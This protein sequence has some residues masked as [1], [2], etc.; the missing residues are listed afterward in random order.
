MQCIEIVAEQLGRLRKPI[1]ECDGIETDVQVEITRHQ[2]CDD[3]AKLARPFRRARPQRLDAALFPNAVH[4]LQEGL[5][6]TR[7][8]AFRPSA[9]DISRFVSAS[10]VAISGCHDV[11]HH[12][13]ISDL[14]VPVN[15]C[16]HHALWR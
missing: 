8:C 1:S 5:T 15:G 6:Q 12:G 7:S 4:V 14:V 16:S 13:I 3:P 10:F 2:K 9:A 11:A